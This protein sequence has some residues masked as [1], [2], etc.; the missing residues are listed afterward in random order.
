[1]NK[2]RMKGIA[3]GVILCAVLTATATAAIAAA[4]TRE[5]TYGVGVT[6]H[7]RT[8]QFDEA[9]RPFVSDGRTF[10]PVR[11]LA[12]LLGLP[13]DFDVEN[14]IVILGDRDITTIGTVATVNG[15]EI[16]AADISIWLEE[17]AFAVAQTLPHDHPRAVREEAVRIVA[18]S[19]MFWE[20]A[21]AH[22][23]TLSAEQL[24]D[25]ESEIAHMM[26]MF[27]EE[28]FYEVLRG[29][30][31]V[32]LEHLVNEMITFSLVN[33]VVRVIMAS[34]EKL[35]ELGLE[36]PEEEILAAK[37]ILIMGDYENAEALATE[38]AERAKAGEDFAALVAE[39]GQDPGMQQSPEGYTFTR[40]MMVSEFETATAALEIGGISGVVASQF[41]YHIILRVEP[42]MDDVLRP[43]GYD[44]QLQSAVISI[45]EAKVDDAEIIFLPALDL[46]TVR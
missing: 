1:M 28:M 42:N 11:A 8:V 18:S 4:Q 45:F 16:D 24:L 15:I 34:P 27:G 38:L 26:A 12:D 7:G 10:L 39:Y 3:I 13:V 37:H 46:V 6:L 43:W 5:I 2:E 19:I 35:A 23:I 30:G 31:F 17:A 32:S 22:G 9:D 25:I 36:Q 33:E 14:N 21:E 29:D 41:G 20:Y 40:G 44:N